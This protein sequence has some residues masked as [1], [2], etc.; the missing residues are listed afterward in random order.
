M[1]ETPLEPQS[2]PATLGRMDDTSER[3]FE[4]L[5][6]E[7]FRTGRSVAEIGQG[8]TTAFANI[9]SI[10][11]A[12]GAPGERNITQRLDGIEGQLDALD[13]RV[14]NVES[15]LDQILELLRNK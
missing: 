9:D 8:L 5:E 3:R 14:G 6:A 7:A 11:D 12:I 10:G 13:G 1:S 15:K 4:R 2:Q